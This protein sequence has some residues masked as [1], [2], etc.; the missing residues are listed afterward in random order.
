ME[1]LV[2]SGKEGGRFTVVIDHV[3]QFDEALSA[4][5]CENQSW[6]EELVLAVDIHLG[7]M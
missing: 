2:R 4:R 6:V 3:S 7:E 1:R 5:F